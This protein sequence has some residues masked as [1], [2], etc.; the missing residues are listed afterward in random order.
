MMIDLDLFLKGTYANAKIM[1]EK[2]WLE[3]TMQEC[4]YNQTKAAKRMGMS[5][6]CLR[7]KLKEHFGNSYFRDIE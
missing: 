2:H 1:F 3:R 5:R 7:T 4:R 6:G